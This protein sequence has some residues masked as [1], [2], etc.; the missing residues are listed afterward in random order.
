MT[1]HASGGR[2]LRIATITGMLLL[3]A[4]A[5][6]AWTGT[7]L[8]G[9][10]QDTPLAVGGDVAAPALPALSLCGLALAAA[11]TI[12][13][14]FFRAVL[15]VLQVLLGISIALSGI[16]VLGNPA[17]AAAPAVTARTGVGG[18]AGVAELLD[19]AT[20]TALPVLAVAIGAASAALG[21]LL[22][23]T[24]RHWPT[25]SRRFSTDAADT[26]GGTDPIEEWDALSG[27]ADPTAEPEVPRRS[28]RDA[29]GFE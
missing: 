21:V 14:P 2:R 19:G 12:S 26:A 15:A 7:W 24:S 20:A 28:D 22:P 6:A 23:A 13:G 11:L 4:L 5:L 1:E 10:V 16:L 17:A 27:G 18:S 9:R 3:H 29:G 25:R 8:T